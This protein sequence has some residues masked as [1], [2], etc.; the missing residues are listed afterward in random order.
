[1]H[2]ALIHNCVHSTRLGLCTEHIIGLYKEVL[3]QFC[4]NHAFVTHNASMFGIK[5]L[6][7]HTVNLNQLY[8]ACTVESLCVGVLGAMEVALC[9]VARVSRCVGVGQ[10]E[11]W[12]AGAC[13]VALLWE[14]S[15][16]SCL[17]V[18]RFT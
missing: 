9:R 16:V 11:I 3:W 4:I 14:G 2:G 13:G 7:I 1:M 6:F 15:V 8:E 5:F 18:T 17:F 10:S 12:G